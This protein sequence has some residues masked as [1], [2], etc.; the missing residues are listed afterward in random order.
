MPGR[1]SGRSGGHLAAP[2]PEDVVRPDLRVPMPQRER[3][4]YLSHL[5]VRLGRVPGFTTGFGVIEQELVLNV[6]PVRR[7]AFLKALSVGCRYDRQGGLWC[8]YQVGT[9]ESLCPANE[10]ERAVRMIEEAAS[11]RQGRRA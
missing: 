4:T 11:F 2:P 8:F 6:I 9:G 10:L 3:V 7:R 5:Q 1:H